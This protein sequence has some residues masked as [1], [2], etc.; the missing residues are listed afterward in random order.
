MENYE[1]HPNVGKTR[2]PD[3]VANAGSSNSAKNN[4]AIIYSLSIVAFSG[5]ALFILIKNKRIKNSYAIIGVL[6]FAAS[7]YFL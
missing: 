2:T 3:T 1:H 4:Y 6:S 5:I 7:G